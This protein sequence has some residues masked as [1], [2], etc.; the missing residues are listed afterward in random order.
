[1]VSN[2][3]N[4]ETFSLIWLD[5]TVNNS[6]ENVRTQQCL[7]TIINH[8]VPFE[9]S[10]SCENYIRLTSNHD[11]LIIIVS[12]LNGRDFVPRIHQFEQVYSI[13]VYCMNRK[14][15]QQWTKNFPKV[16]HFRFLLYFLDQ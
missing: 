14:T 11:R 12:G 1:M 7:R 4:L 9:D 15:N 5:S 16:K 6:E 10:K 8:F 2:H 3:G 13:Y